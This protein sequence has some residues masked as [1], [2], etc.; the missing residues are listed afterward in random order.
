MCACARVSVRGGARQGA[1]RARSTPLSDRVFVVLKKGTAVA[2]WRL[3][4]AADGPVV[5][6][7]ARPCCCRRRGR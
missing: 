1:K 4:R 6:D 7:S 2:V 5:L 3:V